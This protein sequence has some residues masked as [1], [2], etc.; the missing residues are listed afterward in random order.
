[1]NFDCWD[2]KDGEGHTV[3]IVA[4]YCGNLPKDFDYEK[5]EI[6]LWKT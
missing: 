2:L 5:Y 1:M 3:A 6:F 4:L